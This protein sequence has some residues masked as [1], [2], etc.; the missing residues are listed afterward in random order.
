[1]LHTLS[2]VACLWFGCV[3]MPPEIEHYSPERIFTEH[4]SPERARLFLREEAPYEEN[5]PSVT[6]P[7][8]PP[9][10]PLPVPESVP[11]PVPE[12]PPP[13]DTGMGSGVEQWRNLTAAYFGGEVDLA[14]CL[15]AK[16][17]GG[18]PSAYNSSSGASGLMQVMGFWA[19]EFGVT[20]DALFNPDTN[21][22]IAKQIRDMQGWGAWSPY[23]RGECR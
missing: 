11:E 12:P 17:S 19:D 9:S 8:P 13:T 10:E 21:L 6:P 22:S 1:M 23:K 4:F 18:N 3:D 16:E 2:I 5:T 7:L 14:L 15:M 20:R